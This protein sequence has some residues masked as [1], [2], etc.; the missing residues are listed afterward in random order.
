MM[1]DFLSYIKW[2]LV[3]LLLVFIGFDLKS[4][5]ISMTKIEDVEKAVVKAAEPEGTEPAQN[6]IF[7]RFYGLNAKDYE[8]VV[9]YA[10]QDTMDAEELLIVKL[11]DRSQ[12]KAVKAAI[13]ERLETQKKS[14][15]GYGAEQTRLL[16]DHVL[17]VKGNYI[18][19]MVG[20]NA[21]EA[22]AAFL[23]SL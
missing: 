10:P 19:Y 4:D 3:I 22:R 13:E 7:K 15:E 12:S 20:E 6:R 9:L 21:E 18:F 11:S 17:E 16:E 23:D 2:G 8:G 5:D 14:F 1:K